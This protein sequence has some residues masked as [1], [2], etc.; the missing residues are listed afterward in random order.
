MPKSSVLK[1]LRRYQGR[2]DVGSTFVDLVVDT[3]S[4]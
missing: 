4:R 3:R 2:H 1:M